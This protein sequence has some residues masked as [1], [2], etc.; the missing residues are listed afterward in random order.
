M[1]PTSQH[2]YRPPR[3]APR[4]VVGPSHASLRASITESAAVRTGV[5]ERLQRTEAELSQFMAALSQ[6]EQLGA[7]L[8]RLPRE[9][10]LEIQQTLRRGVSG[11]GTAAL[12]RHPQ[13]AVTA[14]ARLCACF[15]QTAIRS[16]RPSLLLAPPPSSTLCCRVRHVTC[17]RR[18]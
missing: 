18:A 3:R 13:T 1:P 6:V 14:T 8:H 4:F 9:R 10:L 12:A 17:I 2:S 7:S 11:P 15:W 16:S 5:A